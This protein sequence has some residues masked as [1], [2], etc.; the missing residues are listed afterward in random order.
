[1][2]R[3][4]YHEYFLHVY[5][6]HTMEVKVERLTSTSSKVY[7]FFFDNNVEYLPLEYMKSEYVYCSIVRPVASRVVRLLR[8]PNLNLF[9]FAIKYRNR[10]NWAKG[11]WS[12]RQSQMTPLLSYNRKENSLFFLCCLFIL[13]FLHSCFFLVYV[14]GRYG[15]H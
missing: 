5:F 3:R 12:F 14:V 6:T 4:D 1:M 2:P 11:L 8:G 13:C 15:I 9:L 7:S 10:W